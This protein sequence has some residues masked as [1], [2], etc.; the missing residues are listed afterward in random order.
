MSIAATIGAIGAIGGSAIGAVG[1][2]KA[3]GAQADAAKSAAELQHEDQKAS[4]AEQQREFNT[5]QTNFAPFLKAGTSSVNALSNLLSTPGQGLLAPFTGQFQ[6]P[7]ADQARQTPGYQFAQQQGQNSIQNSAAARGGLL[8]TGAMKTLDQYSQGL[9][10][11]T[12]SD[13]YNRS[14]NEYLQQYNQF[15]NNQTNT[16]NRLAVASGMGQTS[17]STLGNLNQQGASNVTNIN[18]IGGAQQGGSLMAGGA[19][20][21]SGYAGIA[22]ALNGGISNVNQLMLLNSL[23]G[24]GGTDISS[25]GGVPQTGTI[26]WAAPGVPS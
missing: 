7:T 25:L 10:D 1:S 22:N 2:S 15:Q 13:T 19:A 17:A 5:N 21:A 9:A 20:R 3:A 24:K 4:L 12:Y 16:F 14:F 6:A 8:S 23:F 11:T 18:A 26:D